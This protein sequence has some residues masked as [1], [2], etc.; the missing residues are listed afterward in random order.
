MA[1]TKMLV[2][3]ASATG[4]A[5]ANKLSTWAAPGMPDSSCE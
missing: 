2:L 5:A 4:A 1:A 3:L